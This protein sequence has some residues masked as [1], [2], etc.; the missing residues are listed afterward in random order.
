MK[1]Q[2]KVVD[3]TMEEGRNRLAGID[4]TAIKES[5][6]A[7]EIDHHDKAAERLW[8]KKWQLVIASD[9]S[10]GF[11]TATSHHSRNSERP[12]SE[13][14]SVGLR[15]QQRSRIGRYGT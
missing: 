10:G 2:G 8:H 14:V 7:A 5:I 3:L 1:K 11:V 4:L 6:M 15:Q 12:T 13:A 9:D